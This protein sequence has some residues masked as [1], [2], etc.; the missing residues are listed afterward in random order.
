VQAAK[1]PH[2]NRR[3]SPESAVPRRISLHVDATNPIVLVGF[4]DI[5]LLT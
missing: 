3:A 5:A 1:Q 2:S 4:D